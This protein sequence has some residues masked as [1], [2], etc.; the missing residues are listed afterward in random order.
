MSRT[1]LAGVAL[2]GVV[3][4]VGGMYGFRGLNP[5]PISGDRAQAE[6]SSIQAPA[7]REAHSARLAFEPVVTAG[8]SSI[9]GREQ[10]GPLTPGDLQ[11]RMPHPFVEFVYDGWAFHVEIAA[12]EGGDAESTQVYIAGVNIAEYPE[13]RNLR[14]F[15][16][17]L[18]A[19]FKGQGPTKDTADVVILGCGPKFGDDDCDY[20]SELTKPVLTRDGITDNERARYQTILHAAVNA[21]QRQ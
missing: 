13:Y 18:R 5:L 12:G 3:V 14:A 17:K 16:P 8:V 7:T 6:P 10:P 9:A 1:R 2:C 20:F 4:V 21:F 15:D 11:K 19:M